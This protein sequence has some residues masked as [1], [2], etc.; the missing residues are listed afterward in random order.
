MKLLNWIKNLL[1]RGT[2]YAPQVLNNK[3]LALIEML[4]HHLAVSTI[5][6]SNDMTMVVKSTEISIVLQHLTVAYLMGYIKGNMHLDGYAYVPRSVAFVAE[7][8]GTWRF[9]YALRAPNGVYDEDKCN[10]FIELLN[11]TNNAR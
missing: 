3:Q 5:N 4:D 8:D 7:A 1:K 11:R 2:N 10:M 9:Y 6:V